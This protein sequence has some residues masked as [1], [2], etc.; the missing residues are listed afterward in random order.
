MSL[1]KVCQQ[2][3][4]E[5]GEAKAVALAD[6]SGKNVRL[7][8]IRDQAGDWFAVEELCP[9]GEV[10]LTEG[11]IGDCEVECWAHSAVFNLAT[12]E[13]TLPSPR[14]LITYPLTL[15]GDDVLVDVDAA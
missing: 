13:A 8:I 6:A 10:S 1:Q 9:H 5:P 12:G 11:E 2:N 3:E 7:A 15:D 14:P 4:I